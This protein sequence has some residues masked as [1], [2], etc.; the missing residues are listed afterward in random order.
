MGATLCLVKRAGIA[1]LIVALALAV[2]LLGLTAQNEGCLP[3]QE[4]VGFGDGV[5]GEQDDVSRCSG[6]RLPFGSAVWALQHLRP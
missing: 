5:F 2:I 6:S 3:W 4:R 1:G